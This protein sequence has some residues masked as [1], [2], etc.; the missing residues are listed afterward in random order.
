MISTAQLDHETAIPKSTRCI[1]IGHDNDDDDT[2]MINSR[3][4]LILITVIFTHGSYIYIVHDCHLDNSN[5][6]P[7]RLNFTEV[8]MQI[9]MSYGLITNDKDLEIVAQATKLSI[10]DVRLWFASWQE[11]QAMTSSDHVVGM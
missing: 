1:L 2:C 10:S 11:S 9:L 4:K 5:L 7:G 8:Q 3:G 6:K